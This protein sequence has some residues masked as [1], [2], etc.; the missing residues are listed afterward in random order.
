MTGIGRARG[1]KRGEEEKAARDPGDEASSG[2]EADRG[3]G[4]DQETCFGRIDPLLAR[5]RSL[6]PPS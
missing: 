1:S 2:E 6:S 3:G 4:D 5:L